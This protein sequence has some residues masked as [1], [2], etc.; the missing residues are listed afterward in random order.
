MNSECPD[1]LTFIKKQQSL[2]GHTHSGETSE[3]VMALSET[4]NPNLIAL[5]LN[6]YGETLLQWS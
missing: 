2:K 1:G 6:T 3:Q 4:H 5:K